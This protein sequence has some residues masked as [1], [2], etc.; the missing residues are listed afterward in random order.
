M[1]AFTKI[2]GLQH[3]SEDIFKLLDKKNLMK[4]RLVNNSWKRIL[5]RPIFWLK[6]LKS[7]SNDN[8][9]PKDMYQTWGRLVQNLSDYSQVDEK[10]FVLI[11]MKTF[12]AKKPMYPLGIA[13]ELDKASWRSLFDRFKNSDLVNFILEHEDP[14]R[15]V[16][17]GFSFQ[18]GMTPIHF[19]ARWNLSKVVEKLVLQDKSLAMAK[20][21]DGKTPIHFAAATGN[22]NIVKFLT[23]Y[24]DDPN[25]PDYIGNTPLY[26]AANRTGNLD[27]V[28]HLA[29][30]TNK[31]NSANF[32]G[33]TP[34]HGAAL[35]GY[36]NIVKFLTDFTD[37]PNAPDNS[38]RTP[39]HEAALTGKI[40]VVE[41]LVNFTDFPNAPNNFGDTPMH[42]AA[43]NGYL[44]IVQLLVKYTDNPNASNN[45]GKTPLS[46][47]K[48]KG[49][50]TIAKF[51]DDY[52]KE[53][54]EKTQKK[55]KASSQKVCEGTTQKNKRCKIQV[56][57]VSYCHHHQNN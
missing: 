12:Y 57:N 37:A 32:F 11:M 10:N 4:S 18:K 26:V 31:P 1:Q 36:L 41:F 3:I 6:K 56:F 43:K 29:N 21:G 2:P 45:L 5:D 46:L 17:N 22:L 40:N 25:V 35:T 55:R 19:A 33:D 9:V 44:D 38:G 27:V 48:E 24:T 28:K 8:V 7:E 23:K 20:A 54:N 39:I 34:I 15:T 51:L 13:V 42:K 52:I 49:N 53:K 50:L 47:A 30:F 14:N 16:D